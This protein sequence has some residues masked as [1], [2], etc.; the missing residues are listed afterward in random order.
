MKNRIIIAG[1][2]ALMV[3]GLCILEGNVQ[4]ERPKEPAARV[5]SVYMLAGEFRTV[6][7]NLLW[8]KADA[9]HHEFI[10]HNSNWTKDNELMGLLT[11]ITTLDPHFVEAYSS[12]AYIYADGQKKPLKAI[13][14][15]REGLA[16]NPKSW[17][18]HQ[19][20][21]IMYVRKLNNPAIA[22]PHQELAVKYC[23][24][25]FNK[26]AARKLLGVIQRLKNKSK[27]R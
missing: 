7:A 10:E 15:L 8:I 17:E 23:E 18:L 19:Q 20:L 25:D 24:D 16:S 26:N 13:N 6:F 1:L 22:L 4:S 3:G 27:L 2:M 14:Y 21:A 11:L 5:S 12:G 9:Y